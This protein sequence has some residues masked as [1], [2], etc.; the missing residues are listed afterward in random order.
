MNITK[1][2]LIFR[3]TGGSD[4]R[5]QYRDRYMINAGYLYPTK[6]SDLKKTTT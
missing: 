6:I 5:T 3:E 1:N 2:S 4:G